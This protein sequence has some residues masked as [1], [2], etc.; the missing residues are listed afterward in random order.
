MKKIFFLL[1][2][3][4]LLLPSLNKHSFQISAQ[5]TRIQPNEFDN[6]KIPGWAKDLRR[7]DIITFGVF[8]FSMF[9]VT[10][11]T[12]MIRWYNANGLNISEDGRRYAPWPLK[13]AGAVEMST[14]EHFRT[15][16]IAAGVS[17]VIA[18]IDY[19]IVRIKRNNERKRM[20]SIPVG[21]VE[22]ERRPISVPEDED[23]GLNDM[24][25]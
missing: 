6:I 3:F 13:S 1:I 8:P 15:I 9:F 25:Q 12:D 14:D 23:T 2:I 16:L 18:F 17:L 22:I 24:E 19:M 10:F 4:S 11:A 7:F 21:S 5:Q 20:E